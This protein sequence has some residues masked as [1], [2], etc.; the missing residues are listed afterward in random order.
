MARRSARLAPSL[1]LSNACGGDTGFKNLPAVR[2]FALCNE[3]A[4]IASRGGS[5]FGKL[6][7]QLP[8]P[9][10]QIRLPVVTGQAPLEH[11]GPGG[12]QAKHQRACALVGMTLHCVMRVESIMRNLRT[13]GANDCK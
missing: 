13:L 3:I 5:R 10:R 4:R 8:I 9:K 2:L 6:F 1:K 7:A 12:A 11:D